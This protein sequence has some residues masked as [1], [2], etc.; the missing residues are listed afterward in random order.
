[1]GL[2]PSNGAVVAGATAIMAVGL[3]GGLRGLRAHEGLAP[4]LPAMAAVL[5]PTG[6]GDGT[7]LAGILVLALLGFRHAKTAAASVNT[8]AT[9]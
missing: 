4:A 2:R 1:M 8:P 3:V 9:A 5:R 7:T 6:V